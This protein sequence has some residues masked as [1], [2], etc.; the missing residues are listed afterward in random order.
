[1]YTIRQ[2]NENDLTIY[3]MARYECLKTYPESFGSTF[4]EEV[5][6][7]ELL[8]DPY[9]K[10]ADP[11]NFLFGAFNQDHCIGLCGFL[12]NPKIKL[13]HSGTLVHLYVHRDFLGN[14]IGKRLMEHTIDRAFSLPDLEFILL[15]V[16]NNNTRAI[17]LYENLGFEVYGLLKKY[18][19]VGNQYKDQLMMVRYSDKT[20]T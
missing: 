15:N 4:Q 9:L 19:R 17:K 20:S 16:L 1:M 18:F 3:R 14:G 11:D 12:R 5:Q 6:K 13:R 2:L 8:F 7:T 10:S